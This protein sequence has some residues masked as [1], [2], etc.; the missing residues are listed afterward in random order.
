VR[1]AGLQVS[2]LRDPFFGVLRYVPEPERMA[3]VQRAIKSA[4]PSP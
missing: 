4:A 2:D 3:F 1:E